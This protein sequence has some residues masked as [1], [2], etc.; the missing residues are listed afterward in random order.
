V[1]P[2]LVIGLG[3][4]LMG[5]DGVAFHLTEKLLTDPR[6]PADAEVFWAGDDLLGCA[7]RMAGRTR[8]T[9]LDAMLDP[10]EPGTLRVFD[11]F[12]ALETEQRSAHQLSAAGA[13]ELL[14][15][16]DPSL[17]DIRFKFLAVTVISAEMRPDLSPALVSKLPQLLG[18]V[19]VELG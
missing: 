14:R 7:D 2:H 1:K 11:D 13:I 15:I 16:A 4:P 17:R 6:L 19:L 12:R 9:L 3:N 18:Q 8:V 10:S 5:D